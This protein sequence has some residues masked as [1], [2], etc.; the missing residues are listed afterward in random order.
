MS[1]AALNAGRRPALG[2]AMAALSLVGAAA[3]WGLATVMTKATLATLP[4][5][6]LLTIQL[7]GSIT[8]LWVAV[9]LLRQSMR[10]DPGSRRAAL[11]GLLEPGLAYAVAIP[12]LALT[13]AANASM[14]GAAEPVLV[15][16]VAWLLLG[17]RPR[18]VVLLAILAATFAVAAVATRLSLAR[19]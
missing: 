15:C 16:A 17:E 3:S 8:F 1:T 19:A 5:F 2:R 4:P 13:S 9:L 10:L 14:I 18:P 11:S 7:A 6:T 12:G